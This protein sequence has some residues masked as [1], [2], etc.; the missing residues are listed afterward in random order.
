MGVCG[1]G[2]NEAIGEG[3]LRIGRWG[4]FLE[5]AEREGFEP[6]EPFWGFGGLA[7]HCFRP[8]SHLSGR[9]SVYENAL[10]QSA[11]V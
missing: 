1:I 9:I 8:L 10:S 4:G 3:K 5:M 2:S 6:S 11:Q 7:N